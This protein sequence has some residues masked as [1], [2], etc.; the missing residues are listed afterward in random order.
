MDILLSIVESDEWEEYAPLLLSFV[1]HLLQKNVIF[2]EVTTLEKV[3]PFSKGF[4]ECLLADRSGNAPEAVWDKNGGD[5][6][7]ERD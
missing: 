3:A 1:V 2:I 7:A 4:N 5:D 6:R